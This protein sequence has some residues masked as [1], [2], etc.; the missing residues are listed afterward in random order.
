[1]ARIIKKNIVFFYF[2]E[3]KVSGDKFKE[4]NKKYIGKTLD[5]KF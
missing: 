2:D 3:K 5:L 1:M 4:Q